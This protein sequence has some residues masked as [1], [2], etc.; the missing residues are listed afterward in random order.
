MAYERTETILFRHCDP[1]GIVFYPRY[2]EMINDT[3]EAWFREVVGVD[4]ATLHATGAVPTA[5]I[6]TRF[7][8]PSRLGDVVTFTL[9]PTKIGRS[10]L[11]LEFEA[12]A[13][14]ER[15]LSARSTVVHTGPDTRSEPWPDNIRKTII[16]EL[17][18]ESDDAP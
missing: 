18:K 14:A 2:F 4:F 12:H 5:E 6:T 16:S 8:A 7:T 13:G 1:A 10:S 17:K 11:T 9:R 3:V 15:R